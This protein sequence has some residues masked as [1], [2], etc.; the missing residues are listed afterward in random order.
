LEPWD[1]FTHLK[2]QR[3]NQKIS[4]NLIERVVRKSLW[5][6]ARLLNLKDR[7]LTIYAEKRL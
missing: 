6:V 7:D 3:K 1:P 4:L 5:I 2:N